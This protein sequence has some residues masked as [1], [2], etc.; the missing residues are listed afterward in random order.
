[1]PT[2]QFYFTRTSCNW[3]WGDW[4]Q[5]AAGFH[6]SS[7]LSLGLPVNWHLIPNLSCLPDPGRPCW[8][9]LSGSHALIVNQNPRCGFDLPG[10]QLILKQF[11]WPSEQPIRVKI[12]IKSPMIPWLELP[13]AAILSHTP[14]AMKLQPKAPNQGQ[15]KGRTSKGLCFVMF[16]YV[17]WVSLEQV[18]KV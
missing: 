12:K 7:L 18:G 13:A 15:V 1:M 14:T 17:L 8:T 10:N 3:T 16:W 6:E 9:L 5:D 2:G 4:L 11:V